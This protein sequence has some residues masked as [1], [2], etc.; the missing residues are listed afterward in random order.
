MHHLT[1][2]DVVR[3]RGRLN[4]VWRVVSRGLEPK[5]NILQ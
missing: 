3:K 4:T 5:S 1:D 2:L